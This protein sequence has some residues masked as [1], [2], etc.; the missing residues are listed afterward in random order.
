[1]EDLSGHVS[2]DELAVEPFRELGWRVDFVPWR[3]DADW[4][5]FE[6]VLIRSTWDYY[7]HLESFLTA[8]EHIDAETRLL[9]PLE[10]VRWNSRKTY[11]ADL[12]ERGV[13]IVP[14]VFAAHL[15]PKG[16]ATLFDRFQSDRI[17]IKPVVSAGAH[18]TFLLHR[19]LV[20]AAST[21]ERAA[22]VECFADEEFMAQ[23]FIGSVLNEGEYSVFYFDDKF[24]HTVVK[25]PKVRDF[26]VQEEHGGTIRK[27]APPAGLETSARR[28][29]EAIEPDPLYARVDL[30]RGSSGR[31]M[32][33]EVELIEPSLY[34]RTSA[35]ASTR[36]A[37]AFDAW[38]ARRSP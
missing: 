7:K 31:W 5:K 17:I 24:S 32:V 19:D 21:E 29:L 16:L 9:N 10:V 22:A 38:M 15:E 30:V 18:R 23:P 26:R 13:E 12:E 4:S 33:M 25:T 6:A 35:Q 8:L 11:L 36:L 3:A 2:D 27:V 14:T 1:M 28:A 34:L 20:A 37:K